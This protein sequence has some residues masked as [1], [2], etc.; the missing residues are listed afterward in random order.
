MWVF[1]KHEYCVRVKTL[2]EERRWVYSFTYLSRFIFVKTRRVYK[3]FGCFNAD[4]PHD[5]RRVPWICRRLQ[6]A[7]QRFIVIAQTLSASVASAAFFFQ[8]EAATRNQ[9]PKA[10]A[11][12]LLGR[13]VRGRPGWFSKF[14]D[15]LLKTGD[16]RVYNELTG[17]SPDCDK[18]GGWLQY[19]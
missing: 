17:G 8:I 18:Q 7:A 13:I 16:K 11:R 15:I 14:L 6:S 1:I 5:G 12:Q 3:L 10:G 19:R 9:G 2:L 4:W